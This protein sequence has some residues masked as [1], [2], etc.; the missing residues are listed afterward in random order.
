ML[1]GLITERVGNSYH[2]YSESGDF[3]IPLSECDPDYDV[4]KWLGLR[5]HENELSYHNLALLP[6]LPDL[7]PVRVYRGVAQVLT[8]GTIVWRKDCKSPFCAT[9][10]FET[11]PVLI[12][13]P[14]SAQ[15]LQGNFQVWVRRLSREEEQYFGGHFKW[16]VIEFIGNVQQARPLST[17]RGSSDIENET[18]SARPGYGGHQG[19]GGGSAVP[20][21]DSREHDARPSIPEK[22]VH[23]RGLIIS[24]PKMSLNNDLT[25]LIWTRHFRGSRGVLHYDSKSSAFRLG[26]WIDFWLPFEYVRRAEDRGEMFEVP[27]SKCKVVEGPFPTCTTNNSVQAS[28]KELYASQKMQNRRYLVFLTSEGIKQHDLI[29]LLEA[30]YDIVSI[31]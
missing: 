28:L 20:L 8:N 3:D 1:L 29:K 12:R 25:A 7:P 10:D 5:L 24:P 27:T 21:Q 17:S 18:P 19:V 14:D 4:G 15:N 9:S 30:V 13:L 26:D 22:E 31:V 6:D 2:V 11:I 16:G 23:L